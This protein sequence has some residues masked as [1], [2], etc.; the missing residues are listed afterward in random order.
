MLIAPDYTEESVEILR[1]KETTRILQDRER[2]GATPGERHYKRVLGG[3]LVQDT[4]GETGRPRRD[5]SPDDNVEPDEPMWGDLLFAWRVAKH[6]SSNAIVLAKGLQTIGIG[7]GQPSRVDATKIAL[8]KA[9]E[10]GH[11]PMG[12]ALA[13]DAFFPFAGRAAARARRRDRRR[14][15]SRAARSATTR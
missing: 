12:A 4:D 1:R 10:H 13:S 6:V 14:S 11:D 9:R 8:D 5:G 3:M 2:R 7:T 15:S